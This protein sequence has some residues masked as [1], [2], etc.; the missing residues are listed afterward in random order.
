[1]DFVC[2]N[3]SCILHT[4]EGKNLLH[5][6]CER[7]DKKM[8]KFLL[9]HHHF[10]INATTEKEGNTPLHII[11]EKNNKSFL[12]NILCPME[13]ISVSSPFIVSKV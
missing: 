6:A 2:T 10:N 13:G 7:G 12:F 4:L 3:Y 8:A 5:L 11:I 1:M 9:T